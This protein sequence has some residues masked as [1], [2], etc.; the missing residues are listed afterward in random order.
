MPA[1]RLNPL[2]RHTSVRKCISDVGMHQIP[3]QPQQLFEYGEHSLTPKVRTR[4]P[5]VERGLRV[6][7]RLMRRRRGTNSFFDWGSRQQK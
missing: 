1:G 4:I 5:I 3:N 6:A 7:C 2:A